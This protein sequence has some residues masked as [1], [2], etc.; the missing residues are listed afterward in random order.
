MVA[1]KVCTITAWR[2]DTTLAFPKPMKSQDPC[3]F[4]KPQTK[5]NMLRHS[6][7]EQFPLSLR[8]SCSKVAGVWAMQGVTD[9]VP[10]LLFLV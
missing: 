8:Q 6:Y 7:L 5:T 4:K 10:P 3:I 9:S 2:F 1:L